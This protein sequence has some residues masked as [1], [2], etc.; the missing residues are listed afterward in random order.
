MDRIRGRLG[1][2]EAGWD[3]VHERDREERK[4]EDEDEIPL[5]GGPPT[6]PQQRW[7]IDDRGHR[8]PLPQGRRGSEPQP[9]PAS[10]RSH[11]MA[12]KNERDAYSK[13]YNLSSP[14]I[15]SG[16]W[17]MQRAN[18]Y[19]HPYPSHRLAQ[20]NHHH[21]GTTTSAGHDEEDGEL[22]NGSLTPE[23]ESD[24][25]ARLRTGALQR[26]GSKAERFFGIGEEGGAGSWSGGGVAGGR[27]RGGV[28]WRIWRTGR[29]MGS[30]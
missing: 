29:G 10:A 6:S 14:P 9:A 15:G 17:G 25:E 8:A 26:T 7:S 4:R 19:N 2:G 27:K 30:D 13:G 28:G 20:Q 18:N 22:S 11:A 24:E 1:V 23:E 5:D 16:G 21:R 3:G 12:D